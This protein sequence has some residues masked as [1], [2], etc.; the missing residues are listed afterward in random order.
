MTNPNRRVVVLAAMACI[1]APLTAS[2]AENGT[3]DEAKALALKA[4][5]LFKDKGESTFALFNDKKGPFADRDLYV[6]V[7]DPEGKVLAHGANDKLVGKSLAQLKDA[8]GKLFVQDMMSI[9]KAN[10]SGWVDYRWPNPVSKEIEPKTTY[11]VTQ[12]GIGF[13]V[14][15]YAAGR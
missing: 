7:L 1:S 6:F 9:V 4:V 5:A 14:G 10:K 11:V 12:G 13:A 3:K 2:A 8:D 15:A